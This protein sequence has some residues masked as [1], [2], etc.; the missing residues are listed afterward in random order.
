M[1]YRISFYMLFI[2]FVSACGGTKDIRYPI[3]TVQPVPYPVPTLSK[4]MQY[5][6]L[7]AVNTMR[8]K[9][10]YCGTK[11]YA[12]VK[13]LTW[14]EAL[15]KASYE[16][17]RDMAI[18][19]VMSHS[20]SGTKSDWT[21]QKQKLNKPSKFSERIENNGYLKHKGVAENI[22][23]GHRTSSEVMQQW[24]NSARH[25]Q[26]IMNPFYNELGMA[27]VKS[28]RGISYWT[29]NFGSSQ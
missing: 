22:A 18:T 12:S 24:S 17:S 25:C 29:Q 6:Y 8:A 10:R 20:G 3:S 9:P 26:N 28:S 4:I 23:Y 5:T 7:E 19:Q 27:E 14:D 13:P 16:H 2:L 15:Y 11:L 21:A 1:I